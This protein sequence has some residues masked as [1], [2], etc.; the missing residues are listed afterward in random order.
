MG[1]NRINECHPRAKPVAIRSPARGTVENGG[2]FR[3]TRSQAIKREEINQTDK[4]KTAGETVGAV[5]FWENRGPTESGMGDLASHGT[6]DGRRSP[7]LSV[8]FAGRSPDAA[9]KK[10]SRAWVGFPGKD[11]EKR[12]KT[13]GFFRPFSTA[14]HRPAL[15]GYRPGRRARPPFALRRRHRFSTA[16]L[17][18]DQPSENR[19]NG[20]HPHDLSIRC[21][22]F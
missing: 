20:Q 19:G 10:S 21:A 14:A 18:R 1:T 6:G 7:L 2:P 22:K 15:A 17:W 3:E 5:I 4:I 12:G 9:A 16:A 13:A 8:Y 11:P